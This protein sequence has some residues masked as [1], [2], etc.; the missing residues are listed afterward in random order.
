MERY[1]ETCDET[2]MANFI[3]FIYIYI[4]FMNSENDDIKTLLRRYRDIYS[5]IMFDT[6]V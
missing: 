2:L 5:N 3:T 1:D 6:E 4:M